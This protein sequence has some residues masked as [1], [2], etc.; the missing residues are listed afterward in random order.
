MWDRAQRARHDALVATAAATLAVV[1]V[2]LNLLVWW[3]RAA[4]DRPVSEY[5]SPQYWL[6][7]EEG[8]SR[9][10]LPGQVVSWL[11]GGS[12]PYDAMRIA[13]LA[14]SLAAVVATLSVAA[15][16][17]VR[18]GTERPRSWLVFAVAV[19]SPLTA[20]LF[21][22]DVGRYDSVGAIVLAAL[23]ALAVGA[24]PQVV[25]AALAAVLVLAATASQEFLFLVVAP[26]ALAVVL[27]PHASP[28]PRL[29]AA[30]AVLAPGALLAAASLLLP[31]DAAQVAAARARAVAAGARPPAS[32]DTVTALGHG[33]DDHL[34]YFAAPTVGE[35]LLTVGL[36]SGL[37]AVTVVLLWHVL[38][39]PSGGYWH[40]VAYFAALAAV[41]SATNVDMR[42][43]WSL[44]LLGVL[45]GLAA[46]PACARGSRRSGGVVCVLAAALLFGAFLATRG[47][48]VNVLDRD[49]LDRLL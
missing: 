45:A 25:A 24:L 35:L 9:R 46:R 12:V 23:V 27:R 16:L 8:F 19:S 26:A 5:I 43:W 37:F 31:P 10:A 1:S 44:A 28:G 17:A 22:R 36:W 40:L 20:V 2:A 14:L 18:S 33:L 32:G 38:G 47:L 34:R 42:R 3:E 7:Y 6:T 39:R 11:S 13:A 15:A 49:A 30:V 4:R 29:P 41:L 21:V 48:P